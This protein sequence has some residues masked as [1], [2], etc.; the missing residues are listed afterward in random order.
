MAREQEY[1]IPSL[2]DNGDGS[3]YG[4]VFLQ[5]VV[6]DRIVSRADALS[7]IQKGLTRWV[8]TTDKGKEVFEEHG[9]RFSLGIL[10][11]YRK[12]WQMR[13]CIRHY[14]VFIKSIK[15]TFSSGTIL[16]SHTD[17]ILEASNVK[18]LE[19]KYVRGEDERKDDGDGN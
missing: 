3:Q 6:E 12:S 2:Y 18:I 13:G 8:T 11:D 17:F 5:C 14:G 7:E 9:K 10:Y 4:F 15:G 19:D 1:I 16:G